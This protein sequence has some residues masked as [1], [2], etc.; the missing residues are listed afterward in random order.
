MMTNDRWK[1]YM[2]ALSGYGIGVLVEACEHWKQTQPQF[3]TVGELRKLCDVIERRRRK[4]LTRLRFLQWCV[5]RFDGE[6]PKLM[7]RYGDTL[8]RERVASES[9][10]EAVMRGELECGDLVWVLPETRSEEV[11]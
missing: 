4:E 3:P 2:Q 10:L 9:M 1:D 11:R 6:V 8:H 5:E 7:R